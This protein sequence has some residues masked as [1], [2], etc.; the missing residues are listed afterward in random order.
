MFGLSGCKY[1][2]LNPKGMLALHEKNLLLTS[3]L[4]MLLVV[5]P[6]IVLTLFFAW[7]YRASNTKAT[8]RPEWAHSTL[9]EV[10]WWSIPCVIIGILGTLTWVSSHTL[11]P[12]RP[13]ASK[14]KPLIIQ[15]VALEWKWLF[16]YPEQK[17][18]TVNFLQ[19]PVNVPVKFV[20][21]AE[22]PMNS[23][24][25]PQLSGQIYAMAGM[26]TKLHL[27]A[28]EVGDYLGM[29]SNFSGEGFADMK[30]TLRASTMNDFNAWVQQVQHSSKELTISQY[31]KLLQRSMRH[32]IEYFTYQNN[33]VVC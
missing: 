24:Q 10:I 11:D 16:I 15:V 8:Y 23:L 21:S 4:L 3:L 5:I 28:N 30:F 6:V 22:G 2:M 20:I 18:A 19:V 31:S 32:P 25:I 9:L 26:K 17:I 12:Y 29:S 1:A 33:I 14:E 27:I 7:R 13:L